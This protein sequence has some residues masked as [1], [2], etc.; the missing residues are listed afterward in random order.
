MDKRIMT[1]LPST[2]LIEEN[3]QHR[4]KKIMFYEPGGSVGT[5]N[6]DVAPWGD[7]VLGGT[8]EMERAV[9]RA[10]GV[11]R[12]TEKYDLF[13][14]GDQLS[15]VTKGHTF[16]GDFG[17]IK[18]IYKRDKGVTLE[19]YKIDEVPDYIMDYLNK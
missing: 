6:I 14:I 12:I 16:S 19:K 11:D 8:Q 17:D 13:H 5:N 7:G 18:D 9:K 4:I 10:G 3:K 15:F 1:F 2:Y